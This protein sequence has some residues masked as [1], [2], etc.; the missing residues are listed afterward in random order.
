M[1]NH[2]KPMSL[3]CCKVPFQISTHFK[4][5]TVLKVIS[6]DKGGATI[7]R[8]VPGPIV[9]DT[10]S[11]ACWPAPPFPRCSA[12]SSGP[13]KLLVCCRQSVLPL[14]PLKRPST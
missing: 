11:L 5:C 13:P 2:I 14:P 1:A 7:T 4:E 6:R 8:A 12:P 3:E 9:R 10:A